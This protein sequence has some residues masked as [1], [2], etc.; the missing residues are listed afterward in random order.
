MKFR[1]VSAVAILLG[2]PLI[3]LPLRAADPPSEAERLQNLENAVRQLQQRNAELEQEVRELKAKGGP[4]RPMLSGPEQKATAGSD[5]KAVFTAPPPPPVDVHPGGS[6]YKLTLGGYIQM[7]FEGGDVSAF[8]GRFGSTA[9]K[10]RFRLRRARI[11]L[12]GDFA[13]QFE[14]K[15]E[16]DFE[17]SDG[18]ASNRTAFEATDIFVNWHAIPE[19]NIKMGQW[20]A[21]FGLE[22]ITPDTLIF[23]IERSLP[24]GAITPERQIGV[25]VWGKPFTNLWPEQKDL[26]TYY[27][28]LFNG[29]GRNTD[30]KSVV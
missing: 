16:G 21:P 8:E 24:T 19:A 17:N 7:N 15:I 13:E 28:G 4:F 25:Q 27:V 2:S 30:R 18:I 1:I 26:L 5:S 23:T 11:N 14:F 10:D 20:K 3:S 29:N 9:L 22:Q 12:T 6:E